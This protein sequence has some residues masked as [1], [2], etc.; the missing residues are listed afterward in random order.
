[1][2][3]I[4]PIVTGAF[5]ENC[6]LALDRGG[7]KL[8]VI[9]PG[10]DAEQLIG[11]IEQ[12]SL[13]VAAILLTHGHIDHICAVEELRQWSG[14]PVL[15]PRA[16]RFIIDHLPEMCR[17]YGLPVKPVPQIDYWLKNESDQRNGALPIAVFE[18]TPIVVH[19][20]P[21]HTPGGVCY[22]LDEHLMTGDTLFKGSIGRTDLP[23]GDGQILSNSIAYLAKLRGELLVY[24]GHGPATTISIECAT[25]PFLQDLP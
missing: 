12:T 25:N 9:D 11:H 23:G 16:D 4:V 14:A 21:G 5:E 20:T 19:A 10:D 15:A 18:S 7:G 17:M 1:M 3:E 22:Q 24:P 6:Y 13:A 8:A 2:L